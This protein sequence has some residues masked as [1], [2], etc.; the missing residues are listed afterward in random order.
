[1]KKIF[2]ILLLAA[3]LGN[4]YA[5]QRT[6]YS[7]YGSVLTPVN[8]AASF[9]RPEGEISVIGR[10]QWAGLEGAP[11]TYWLAASL[12]VFKP[13]ISAGFLV[14][15]ESVAVERS[16]EVLAYGGFSVPLSATDRLA[17]SI[18]AG[19]ATY[20]GNFASLDAGDPT[21]KD[22]VSK[23]EGML[24]LG[25]LYYRPEKYYAGISIPR[26]AFAKVLY[27]ETPPSQYDMSNQYQFTAGA[28]FS[29]RDELDLKTT[30]MA[31]YAGNLGVQA[32]VSPMLLVK[33]TFGLGADMSTTGDLAGMAAIHTG[34]V[35][36][37][38]SYQFYIGN[39]P[40]SRTISNQ[41]HELSFTYRLGQGALRLL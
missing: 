1:M 36:I 23:T 12:P 40:M 17:F 14:R 19:T 11:K 30:G 18:G 4:C 39:K 6:A 13:G 9:L 27:N 25:F 7:Q 8:P 21:F 2:V 41:T 28:L 16:T 20:K 38:Y 10:H 29:L 31:S 22:N 37:G 33:K 26:L 34:A 35:S 5:Q 15:H 24:T 32:R 3:S